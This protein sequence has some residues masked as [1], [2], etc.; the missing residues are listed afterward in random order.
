MPG[1]VTA[2]GCFQIRLR[3]W[4]RIPCVRPALP[5]PKRITMRAVNAKVYVIDTMLMP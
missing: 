4:L 5:E 1:P 2:A 3:R